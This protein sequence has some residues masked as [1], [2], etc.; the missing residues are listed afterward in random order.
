MAI[1]IDG[2]IAKSDGD[3]DWVSEL[4]KEGF[5]GQIKEKGCIILGNK[6]FKQYFN[7]LYPVERVPNI[8]LSSSS[9]SQ[10]NLPSNVFFAKDLDNAIR[11]AK[12][13]GRT[14]ALLIGGSKT[15][16][17]FFKLNLIDEVC[18]VIHPLAFGKGI[19]LFEGF[20][21]EL[22]LEKTSLSEMEGG[23]VKIWYKVVK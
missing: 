21:G 20:E 18:L 5:E 14:Q 19:N 4:D 3:S 22:K 7:E 13:Q 6:T 1:T 2:F 12:D 8:V 10:E 9:S 23:L 16:G 17:T 15:N 11:I